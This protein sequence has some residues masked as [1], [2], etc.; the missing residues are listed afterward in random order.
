MAK[1]NQQTGFD[2]GREH[3]GH[4]YAQGLFGAAE[5]LGLTAQVMDELDSLIDDVL[6]KVPK[7]RE[8]LSTPRVSLT[9]KERLIDRALGGKASTVLVHGLKVMARH[10]RLDVLRNVRASFRTL[11]NE[12]LGKVAVIV[13]TAAPLNAQALEQVANRLR[14]MLGREV[15]MTV[16]VKPELLGG[17]EVR[18][19]D[20]L[21]DGS[22]ISRLEKMRENALL[23]TEERLRE[24]FDKFVSA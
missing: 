10:N 4:V 15:V 1:T 2:A 7:L 6:I 22:L 16:E 24:T 17:I 3:L 11:Y 20:K 5:K 13:R 9:D 23:K 8:T 21:Y 18:V 14:G 12:K 19:G